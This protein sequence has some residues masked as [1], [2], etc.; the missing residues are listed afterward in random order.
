MDRELVGLGNYKGQSVE[1]IAH[2]KTYDQRC[3]DQAFFLSRSKC[4]LKDARTPIHNEMQ[5][6]FLEPEFSKQFALHFLSNTDRVLKWVD[7]ELEP[8][9]WW[10]V[11]VKTNLGSFWVQITPLLGDDW[12][13]VLRK[14][15]SRT[16]PREG[17]CVLYVRDFNATNC[18]RD[19][20]KAAF[21]PFEVLFQDELKSFA[22]SVYVSLF[23]S[24]CGSKNSLCI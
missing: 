14:L 20:L 15:R 8:D 13:C 11:V 7:T 17:S 23:V 12:R 4:S 24:L 22:D 3:K 1:T 21:N 16:K 19:Q 5:L 18:T 10:D 9:G 2:D 6:A